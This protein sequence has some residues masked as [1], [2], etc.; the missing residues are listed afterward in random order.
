[1]PSE[2]RNR[3]SDGIFSWGKYGRKFLCSNGKPE[4]FYTGN[5]DADGVNA[6]EKNKVSGS[7]C[8]CTNRFLLVRSWPESRRQT[9]R[10]PTGRGG[11]V[12][13]CLVRAL[14]S[15]PALSGAGQY[16]VKQAFSDGMPTLVLLRG[17]TNHLDDARPSRN[18]RRGRCLGG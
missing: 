15:L 11:L 18:G 2:N 9:L 17:H 10:I 13:R 7:L 16:G 1:M 6:S 12:P 4:S 5:Y 8:C 14:S 3:A